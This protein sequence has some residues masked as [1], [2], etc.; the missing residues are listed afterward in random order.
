MSAIIDIPLGTNPEIILY[1]L[2]P[3]APVNPPIPPPTPA[4]T[5]GAKGTPPGKPAKSFDV[6]VTEADLAG[7]IV[8]PI[9]NNTKKVKWS[10]TIDPVPNSVTVVLQASNDGTNFTTID[11]STKPNGEIRTVTTGAVALRL[12]IVDINT[13]GGVISGDILPLVGSCTDT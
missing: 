1:G 6:T 3:A 4:Q 10:F 8:I 5:H 12:G 13:P 9:G 11:Y 7:G 2:N